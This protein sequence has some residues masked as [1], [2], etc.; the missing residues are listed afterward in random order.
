[1]GSPGSAVRSEGR[2]AEHLHRRTIG[3]RGRVSDDPRDLRRRMRRMTM[4]G[5]LN[6]HWGGFLLLA[7]LA[8]AIATAIFLRARAARA[9]RQQ[10][11]AL[12][13]GE[14][15]WRCHVREMLP[16]RQFGPSGEL[17][18]GNDDVM[19]LQVDRSSAKRGAQDESWPLATIRTEIGKPRR[20]ITGI[21]YTVLTVWPDGTGRARR[22]GCTHEMGEQQLLLR[23]P[24]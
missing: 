23:S 3:H 20:D 13:A 18:I 7:T 11:A 22:F 21:R 5:L 17:Y 16:G 24:E 19:R 9:A 10:R 12:R 8:G 4:V 2:R 1:M 6:Q 14:L 15:R